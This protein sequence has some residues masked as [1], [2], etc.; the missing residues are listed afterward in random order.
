MRGIGVAD[1][2]QAIDSRFQMFQMLFRP[3]PKALL[4]VDDDQAQI[5]KFYIFRKQP[6][7]PNQNIDL[8]PLPFFQESLSFCLTVAKRDTTPTSDRKAP[9]A[10]GKRFIMLHGKH[11]RR[12]EDGHLLMAIDDRFERSAHGH[13]GLAVADIAADQ[14]VHRSL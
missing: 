5:L 10:L 11:R 4:L 13:L 8:S 7:C 6:M 1:K 12:H 3:D 9:H 14:P 2:C